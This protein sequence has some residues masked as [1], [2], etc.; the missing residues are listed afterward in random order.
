MSRPPVRPAP[1]GFSEEA[2]R[3]RSGLLRLKSVLH[4]RATGLFSYHLFID[5]LLS[6]AD[7]APLGVV[8]LEFPTL[9]AVEAARGWEVGDLLLARAAEGL[10]RARSRLVPDQT[11]VALEGAHGDSFL[12]FVPEIPAEAPLTDHGLD[13]MAQGLR[14]AVDA[15]LKEQGGETADVACAAGHALVSGAPA[16]RFERRLL[17]AIRE[18]R[19]RN[20]MDAE[21][22]LDAR[23]AALRALLAS[24]LLQTHYQPIVDMEQGSIMGYEALTRAPAGTDFES[25]DALFAT[26]HEA[27]LQGELDRACRRAAVR[28]ARGIDPRKKLFLNSL[29]ESLGAP[30]FTAGG[31]LEALEE[32]SL[33]PR[34]LVLEIT[35]RTSI[36]DFE[37]FGRGVEP[38]RRQGFL[39]AID[40]VGTGYSSLQTL[41]EVQPEF[42]KV[43]RSLVKGVHRSL[44]KQELVHSLLQVGKRIGAQVIA[45]GIESEDEVRALR[46]CGVRYGQG[47]WFAYPAPGFPELMPRAR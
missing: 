6:L 32:A 23:G 17:H 37:A 29:P 19:A 36:D 3:L 46:R 34:N 15:H 31:F 22:F 2:E 30:G 5:E 8:A 42:I 16:A 12:V 9:P 21:R 10:R 39:L 25:P 20:R 1:A 24:E 27:R 41:T 45:E 13:L 28:N 43:D 26:C 35:E 11:L 38:L 47:F 7:H 44:L 4:D 14:A 18:A 40:D 33:E